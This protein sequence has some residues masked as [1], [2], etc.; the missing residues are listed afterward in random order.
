M[1][2][3]SAS[4]HQVERCTG[5]G[6]LWFDLREH[7][8]ISES[9]A[10]VEEVDTADPLMGRRHNEMR[11][12]SCPVCRVKMLKL[13][14]PNQLHIKYESCPVCYGAFF[15]AGEFTDYARETVAEQFS[16]FFRGFRRRPASS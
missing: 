11:D 12:V 9:K 6:G 4:E 2:T 3:I 8:R 1:T 16:H 14:V 7:E 10:Q 15:D 5:C 13:S